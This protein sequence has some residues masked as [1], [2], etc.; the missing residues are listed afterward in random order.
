MEAAVTEEWEKIPQDW[1]NKLIEKQEHWV[2]VL[3]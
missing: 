2:M 3:I 1:I